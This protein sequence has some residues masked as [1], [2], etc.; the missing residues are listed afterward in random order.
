MVEAGPIKVIFHDHKFKFLGVSPTKWYC[1][2]L[3]NNPSKKC[4]SGQKAVFEIQK[5]AQYKCEK[6]CNITLCKP[7]IESLTDYQVPK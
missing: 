3:T 2:G 7:C 4:Y 6:G 1:D 5:E